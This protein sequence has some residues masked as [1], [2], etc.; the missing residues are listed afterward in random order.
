MTLRCHTGRTAQSSA[1][2]AIR[3]LILTC[4]RRKTVCIC[5]PCVASSTILVTVPTCCRHSSSICCRTNPRGNSS[6]QRSHPSHGHT[7]SWG[8]QVWRMARAMLT[9]AGC[10]RVLC[11]CRHPSVPR[12]AAATPSMH[13]SWPTCCTFP[14]RAPQRASSEPRR[15]RC[16]R[17]VASVSMAPSNVTD[18]SPRTAISSSMPNSNRCQ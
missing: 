12:R 5:V 8:I 4:S 6:G 7:R 1:L 2:P 13:C 3:Q 18:S 10:V 16:D 11:R 17:A 14:R 15:R 9:V